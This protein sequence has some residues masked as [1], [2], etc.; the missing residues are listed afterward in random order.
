[1]PRR[2]QCGNLTESQQHR[3]AG[4]EAVQQQHYQIQLLPESECSLEGA[5]LSHPR[6]GW[7]GIPGFRGLLERT[8][9]RREGATLLSP[10]D[11]SGLRRVAFDVERW[12]ADNCR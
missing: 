3:L 12:A 2:V 10:A 8:M 4:L 7:P 1:M 5:A 11:C 6:L 9:A